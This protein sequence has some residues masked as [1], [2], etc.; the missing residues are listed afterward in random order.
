MPTAPSPPQR[1]NDGIWLKDMA[2][3]PQRTH[4]SGAISSIVAHASRCP[5]PRSGRRSGVLGEVAGDVVSRRQFLQGR[6][7]RTAYLLRL[8]APGVEPA[9]GRRGG[10]AW[11]GPRQA[12]PFPA[13]PLPLRPPPPLP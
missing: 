11:H 1:K 4:L 3:S 6:R 10:R 8:P 9:G 12:P 13:P 2:L 5:G 7:H